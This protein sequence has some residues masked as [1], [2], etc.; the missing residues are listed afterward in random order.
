MWGL[1]AN[2]DDFGD[3]SDQQWIE[4]YNSVPDAD[5]GEVPMITSL[6]GGWRLFFF[7]E[8]PDYLELVKDSATLKVS[9]SDGKDQVVKVLEIESDGEC[10]Y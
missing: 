8:H 6:L 9:K 1:N 3:R 5:A 7:K 4:L 10:G 2:A